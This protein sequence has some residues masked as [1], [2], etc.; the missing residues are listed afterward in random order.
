M[1]S[2]WH[3]K[4]YVLYQRHVQHTLYTYSVEYSFFIS[5]VKG[6]ELAQ[7]ILCLRKINSLLDSIS[8][9]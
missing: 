7:Q 6:T 4:K 5:E 9:D 1:T 8:L 2:V 3:K